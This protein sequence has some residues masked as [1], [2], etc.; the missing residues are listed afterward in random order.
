MADPYVLQIREIVEGGSSQ[1]DKINA[2]NAEL[3]NMKNVYKLLL[4]VEMKEDDDVQNMQRVFDIIPL[5]KE[6]LETLTN[7]D[8]MAG[9]KKSH[10]KKHKKKRKRKSQ[11]K[12]SKKSKRSKRSK[13]SSKK[14]RRRR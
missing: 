10:T 14:S 1:E 8:G 3:E 6:A 11:K 7:G 2:L 13:R 12:K 9:L 5:Y 4:A